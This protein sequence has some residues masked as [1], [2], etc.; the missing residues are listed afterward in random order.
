MNCP[1]CKLDIGKHWCFAA[2]RVVGE[3]KMNIIKKLFPKETKM[4]LDYCIEA[5]VILNPLIQEG[6]SV[7]FNVDDDTVKI[8]IYPQE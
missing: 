5:M 8:Q 1:H 4:D 3:S 7:R 6:T 2:Q